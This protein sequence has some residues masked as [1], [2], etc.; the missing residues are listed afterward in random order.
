MT[1][2][3]EREAFEVWASDNGK[4]TAAVER[5]GDGYVLGSIQAFWM[6]W[7]VRAAIECEHQRKTKAAIQMAYGHL[8]MVNNEPGTPHRYSPEAAAHK[9][10][11]LLR[12][13]LTKEERGDGINSAMLAAAPKP[14]DQS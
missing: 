12:E 8:W 14:E 3:Q 4:Y 2:D 9:A 1:P 5:N 10:R 7:Q 13:L 11:R 6:V